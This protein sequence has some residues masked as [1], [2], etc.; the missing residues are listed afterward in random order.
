MKI[1]LCLLSILGLAFSMELSAQKISM[2]QAVATAL[3]RNQ[4]IMQFRERIE[5]K[6]FSEMESWGNFL[7][8]IS[9][10]GSYTH[11]NKNLEIDLG[12]I[13]DAMIQLQTGNQVTFATLQNPALTAQQK[14]AIAAQAK[15]GLE[16]ALPP[17]TSEFK[18]QDYKTATFV[19]IQPLFLGGKLWAAKNAAKDEL[20]S[21]E[22]ELKKTKDEIIQET[23]NNYLSV[24]LVSDIIKTR[25]DVLADIK[26]HRERAEK[27]LKEGLIAN[28]NLLRAKVAE[29]EAE[30]ALFDDQ[31]KLT[32]AYLALKNSMG[33]TTE[34]IEVNDSLTYKPLPDSLSI[35]FEKAMSNNSILKIINIK[36]EAVDEKYAADRANFLPQVAAFGKYELYPEYLSLLEPRWAVGININFNLFNGFK[37]YS[38]LQNTVHLQDELKYLEA[39]TKS[40]IGLLINKTYKDILN[41]RERYTRAEDGVAL[42]EENLRLNEKRFETG[43]GTSLEVIDAQLSYEKIK[44]DRKAALYD[45][46]KAINDLLQAS[47]EP[48]N[49]LSIWNKKEK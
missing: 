25:G 22:I 45:Y 31:N 41:A 40:K 20:I 15:A 38:K 9:I 49:V 26:R 17:F 12:P 47:G 13:R 5:Q 16:A 39:D 21:S 33:L 19:G 11:L 48:E 27:L 29:S 37:D 2:E 35:Y 36:K 46:Y 44:L 42:A 1:K 24:V 7:P 10:T 18:K 28:Y 23:V 6:K 30:R 3:E 34:E 14:A 43:L 4:K 32:V 8:Q